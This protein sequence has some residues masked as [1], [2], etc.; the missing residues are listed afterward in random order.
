MQSIY[1][2]TKK[3]VFEI[4]RQGPR[5]GIAR[6]SFLG[7]DI[8]MVLPDRRDG[9]LYATPYHGHFGPKVQRS[10]DGGATWEEITTPAFPPQPKGVTEVDGFGKALPWKVV[11]VWALEPGHASEPGVLWVGT[12]PGGLFRSADSGATWELVRSLWDDPGRKQWFGG[13]ADLPGIHSVCV[14]PQNARHVTVGVSCGGVWV[15][16][17]GGQS[18]K[19]QADGMRA[20]YMPPERAGDPNIQD[21]HRV[22]QCAA[23]PDCL[24]AQHHNGIFRSDNAG[25]SWQEIRNV[26][27]SAFGFA[28]AVHPADARTAWFIPAIK[29]ERRIPVDGK[30]VVTRT[31]NAGQSF[32]ILRTGLPQEHAYDIVYRHAL[33]IDPTGNVLAFGTTTGSFWV[34]E[35]QGDQWQCVSAH[36]PPVFCVRFG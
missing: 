1:A 9:T 23:Q 7:D 18:W 12:I 25:Q 33:D 36:L 27:P 26:P 6:V 15:T 2:A 34:S 30:L 29:D 32:D 3:G 5:W 14:H 24:W 19:V 8:S 16:R 4:S 21:P 22:V 35:D 31:R 10:R 17:D 11:K 13:G 20:E 28:V